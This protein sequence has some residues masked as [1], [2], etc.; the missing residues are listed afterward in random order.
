VAV[1]TNAIGRLD[2]VVNNPSYLNINSIEAMA[3]GDF[4]AQIETK[5]L[6]VVTRPAR[7]C[8]S[9]VR[10]ATGICRPGARGHDSTLGSHGHDARQTRPAQIGQQT[11][12]VF[13]MG[14]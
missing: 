12:S 13:G 6:G 1:A 9:S 10:S 2:V 14:I 5:V 7:R 3:E 8:P 4:R 11:L